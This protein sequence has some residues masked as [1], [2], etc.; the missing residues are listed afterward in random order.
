MSTS[1]TTT[2]LNCAYISLDITSNYTL[3]ET[4]VAS[5]VGIIQLHISPANLAL[6]LNRLYVLQRDARYQSN[7]MILEHET[8]WEGSMVFNYYI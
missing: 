2:K 5:P 7:Q 6:H 3:Q 8:I 1:H 4:K